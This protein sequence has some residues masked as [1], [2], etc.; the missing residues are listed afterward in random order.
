MKR[1]ALLLAAALL[2]AQVGAPEVEITAEP[3]HHLVL[4]NK[5]VRVF[6]VE[7][8]P[9]AE[10]QMHWHR[11][12][13]V[14]VTLGDTEIVNIV[15]DKAPV[16]VKLQDGETRFSPATF[17]HIV[18]NPMNQ[19]FRNVTI[20]ILEDDSLRAAASPWDAKQNGDRGLNI[21]QG[22][23]QQILFVKD[24]IRVSEV[25][26]Q[27]GGVFP[28]SRAGL[29]VAVNDFDLRRDDAKAEHLR[30]GDSIWFSGKH[31]LTNARSTSAK[32]VMLEFP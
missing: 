32:F 5:S 10:T 1:F 3:H 17:A 6:N 7:V 9:A 20:E 21:L 25:E 15:K 11:H 14:Y 19:P 22:G 16:T 18:R 8:D 29:L 24:A 27:P 23:T 12:D 30:S 4:E 2:A 31:T 28:E 26:L 13:Y